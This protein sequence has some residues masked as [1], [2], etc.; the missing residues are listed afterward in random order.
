MLDG[1]LV[2]AYP[3]ARRDAHVFAARAVVTAGLAQ[4]DREDLEQEALLALWLA[5]PRFDA[6]PSE[7]SSETTQS[8][9]G[10]A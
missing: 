8:K 7:R 9:R 6:S 4:S 3:L 5:L 1:V 2:R 10:V